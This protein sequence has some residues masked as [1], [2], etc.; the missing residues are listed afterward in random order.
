MQAADRLQQIVELQTALELQRRDAQ[1]DAER[2]QRLEE[3][4]QRSESAKQ[5]LEQQLRALEAESQQSKAQSKRL[6]EEM[7]RVHVEGT[8]QKNVVDA[9]TA[10]VKQRTA[11]CTVEL[12]GR[13]EKQEK[14]RQLD[15]LAAQK[16]S[17][18][19]RIQLSQEEEE[20]R[21]V[22]MES[23]TLSIQAL[24]KS[25][26]EEKE[27]REKS[28]AALEDSKKREDFLHQGMTAMQSS[29]DQIEAMLN[30]NRAEWQEMGEMSAKGKKV[31]AVFQKALSMNQLKEENRKLTA[32]VG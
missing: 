8:L 23:Q 32:K 5:K 24:S 27:R 31:D 11:E 30:R 12:D 29:I 3:S 14:E 28:E 7:E 2:L 26:A 4:F 21:K 13:G 17:L 25:L 22:V 19:K 20:K 10:A 16:D 18:E 1:A 15:E 6:E 9:L